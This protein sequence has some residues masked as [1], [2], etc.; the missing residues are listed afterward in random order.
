[1]MILRTK[2]VE[3]SDKYTNNAYKLFE[4]VLWHA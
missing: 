3:F 4:T 2:I 1:M